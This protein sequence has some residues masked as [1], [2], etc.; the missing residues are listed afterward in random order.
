MQQLKTLADDLRAQLLALVS[1]ERTKAKEK[2]N[3]LMKRVAATSEYQ[4]LTSEQRTEVDAPF[5]VCLANLERQK[6]IAV[7]QVTVTNFENTEYPKILSRVSTLA[8]PAPPPQPAPVRESPDRVTP[9]LPPKP[10]PVIQYVSAKLVKVPFAKPWLASD[11]DV[12]VYIEAMREALKA[13]LRNGKQ[14][15]I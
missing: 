9:P 7:I 1:S 5:N 14:I 8:H 4:E 6:L 15:Q 10:Q 2:I 13:E 3:E 11:Q 12:D